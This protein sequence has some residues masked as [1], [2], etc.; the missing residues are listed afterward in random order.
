MQDA[1]T[2]L[3]IFVD[4]DNVLDPDYLSQVLLIKQ[5]NGRYWEVWGSGTTIPE[6]EVDLPQWSTY[7]ISQVRDIANACW[8]NVPSCSGAASGRRD[9][10]A[11]NSKTASCEHLRSSLVQI[12]DRQGKTHFGAE[13]DAEICLVAC[14]GGDFRNGGISSTAF[15][16]ITLIPGGRLTKSYLVRFTE[17]LCD[18]QYAARIQMGR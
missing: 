6:F 13:G 18:L 2:D 7:P 9:V 5:R 17:G 8:S 3:I 1:K 14:R 4:D 16:P 12:S 10:R 15:D 11:K